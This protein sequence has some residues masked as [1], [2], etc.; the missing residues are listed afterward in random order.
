MLVAVLSVLMEGKGCVCISADSFHF[1]KD[2]QIYQKHHR[3]SQPGGRLEWWWLSARVGEVCRGFIV[4][5]CLCNL[6]VHRKV[7]FSITKWSDANKTLVYSFVCVYFGQHVVY[8]IK[9]V[10]DAG[11]VFCL[12][13]YLRASLQ[14]PFTFCRE[15]SV[16]RRRV[17]LCVRPYI[18]K[19]ITGVLKS[20]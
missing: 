5:G 1:S 17:F 2:P 4:S 20:T 13:L 12:I 7:K 9:Y 18:K 3:L 10:E 8:M 15:I 6:V 14:M 16:K 19:N 11:E